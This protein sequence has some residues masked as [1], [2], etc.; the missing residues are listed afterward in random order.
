M[1]P[2]MEQPVYEAGCFK[3]YCMKKNWVRRVI[4]AVLQDNVT[5]VSAGISTGFL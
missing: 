5:A 4:C 1:T 3:E 2:E